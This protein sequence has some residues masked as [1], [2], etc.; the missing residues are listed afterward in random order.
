MKYV[1]EDIRSL[2]D[3]PKSAII[4]LAENP[5]FILFP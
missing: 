4:I 2:Q 3:F 1:N 5:A